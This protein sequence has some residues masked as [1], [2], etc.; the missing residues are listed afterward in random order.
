M[1]AGGLSR[2]DGRPR[3]VDPAVQLKAAGAKPVVPEGTDAEDLGPPE[4]TSTAGLA[5]VADRAE[6]R[7]KRA[8]LVGSART[9]I[10]ETLPRRP[11]R[12]APV[13]VVRRARTAAPETDVVAAG[14][15][16]RSASR[17]P[18]DAHRTKWVEPRMN[19]E[20]TMVF[21]SGVEPEAEEIEATRRVGPLRSSRKDQP[22]EES[23]FRA[24]RARSNPSSPSVWVRPTPAR[25]DRIGLPAG[26]RA[27]RV[28]V[29]AQHDHRRSDTVEPRQ[30]AGE[31]PNSHLRLE[32]RG[33]GYH[34]DGTKSQY[35]DSVTC[36]SPSRCSTRRQHVLRHGAVHAGAR[37]RLY[38][39]NGH[40]QDSRSP[41]T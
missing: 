38:G 36:T 18:G 3:R 6:G 22:L 7:V 16:L 14:R 17:M 33:C 39:V 26:L 31:R 11:G 23:I 41:M 1:Y 37:H 35:I 12:D 15:A 4:P 30:R 34:R 13:R 24:R 21:R 27:H 40:S 2:A 5:D 25:L 10:A 28:Q 8:R 9:D 19:K 29:G 20:S 32:G